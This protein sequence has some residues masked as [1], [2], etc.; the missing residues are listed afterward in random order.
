MFARSFFFTLPPQ[1]ETANL[2]VDDAKDPA[3]RQKVLH[4]SLQTVLLEMAQLDPTA[5]V[6]AHL[7]GQLFIGLDSDSRREKN[8]D[9]K[10][11]L[12]T[13]SVPCNG[14]SVSSL[15]VSLLEHLVGVCLLSVA[16][17]PKLV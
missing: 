17:A 6:P 1:R 11:G 9:A 12:S 14:S 3:D 13:P 4:A 16:A 7:R 15:Y 2:A 5:F 10:P 8:R